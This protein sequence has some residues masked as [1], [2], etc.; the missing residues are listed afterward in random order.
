MPIKAWCCLRKVLHEERCFLYCHSVI[1][2]SIFNDLWNGAWKIIFISLRNLTFTRIKWA[3]SSSTLLTFKQLLEKLIRNIYDGILIFQ[4]LYLNIKTYDWISFISCCC[5]KI[6][7]QRNLRK[8][9]FYPGTS[10]YRS[11][12]IVAES[13]SDKINA[14]SNYPSTLK[15]SRNPSRKWCCPQWAGLP[16]SSDAINIVSHR[17]TLKSLL[18]S[19]AVKLSVNGK[20]HIC[21]K[22]KHLSFCWRGLCC[23]I[24]S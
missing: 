5:S 16:T 21:W 19:D 13:K 8:K 9:E 12:M 4:T 22:V 1:T 24:F 15:Q 10:W 23:N 11:Q 3:I 20:Y 7:W 2:N 14:T 18:P 6:F 17:Y